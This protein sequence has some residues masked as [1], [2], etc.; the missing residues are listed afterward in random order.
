M[1]DK[2]QKESNLLAA[3]AAGD[4]KAFDILYQKYYRMLYS[5]ALDLSKNSHEAE[6]LVQSV[7]VSVWEVRQSIDPEKSFNA[8]LFSIARNRFYN[9]LRKRVVE[10]C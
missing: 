9:M 7:F 4:F 3:I 6:E 10:N 2:A 5:F 8:Y 1:A